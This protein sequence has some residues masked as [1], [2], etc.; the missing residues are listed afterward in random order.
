MQETDDRLR[1]LARWGLAAAGVSAAALAYA[2]QI[3]PTWLDLHRRDLVLPRLPA[4]LEGLRIAHLTDFHL[5]RIVPP[6]YLAACVA[7]AMRQLNR[8]THREKSSG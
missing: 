2:T 8:L 7:A 5:S 6:D 4:G 3:E 1:R